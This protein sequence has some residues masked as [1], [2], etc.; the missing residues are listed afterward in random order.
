MLETIVPLVPAAKLKFAS[1]LRPPESVHLTVKLK[2]PAFLGIPDISP[3][4]LRF[5]PWGNV[6]AV[7]AHT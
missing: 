4:V 6:P 2:V 7:I 5:K 3:L 1:A